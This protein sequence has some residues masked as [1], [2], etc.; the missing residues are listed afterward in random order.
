MTLR[1]KVAIVTGGNSGIG[2]AIT[3][4]FLAEGATVVVA[5]RKKG[6]IPPA[7]HYVETDVRSQRHV[8]RLIQRVWTQWRRL[9][10]VV[11][12]AAIISD[13]DVRAQHTTE[14]H[15][16]TLFSTNF[17]S[18]VWM[19]EAA[20]QYLRKTHGV[21]INIGSRQ[22]LEP[23]PEFPLYGASKAAVIAYT[24]ATA[25]RWAPF[26]I[27][28]NCICPS[29]IDTPLL[30]QAFPSRKRL[31]HYIRQNPMRR[32]G[33]PQEVANLA[34]FLASTES[35]YIAGSIYTIDGGS[36]RAYAS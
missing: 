12:S 17:N 30:H 9:D 3:E 2:K 26:G 32:M 28:I 10:V 21:V 8:Q 5:S 33:T 13:D 25:V 7:S 14:G 35:S 19:T 15:L 4:R 24:T 22:A 20:M 23:S 6:S 16:R 36:S 1:D 27:R 29:M 11:N 31:Q 34:A 18:I